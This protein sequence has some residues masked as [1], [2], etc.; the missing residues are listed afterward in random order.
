MSIINFSRIIILICIKLINVVRS[1]FEMHWKENSTI[2]V[3]CFAVRE[4]QRFF[5]TNESL[6]WTKK[7]RFRFLS[8]S[9]SHIDLLVLKLNLEMSCRASL[10][11]TAKQV[12]LAPAI[13][14]PRLS[15]SSAHK[16]VSSPMEK[17]S[18][19]LGTGLVYNELFKTGFGRV[20]A[21]D[22]CAA[23]LDLYKNLRIENF[24]FCNIVDCRSLRGPL[25]LEIES[26]SGFVQ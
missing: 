6:V 25:W 4:A 5:S 16:F 14:D 10:E 19:K 8:A 15:L 3:L 9:R 23:L 13:W 22:L 1:S 11:N 18:T 17:H 7:L 12:S 2:K 20:I 21:R 26:M 24:A